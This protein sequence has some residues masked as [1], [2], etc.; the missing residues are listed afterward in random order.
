MGKSEKCCVRKS[1]T[2]PTD[3][4]SLRTTTL[5]NLLKSVDTRLNYALKDGKR[6]F[7]LSL[8]HTAQRIMQ[9][10]L[11][12]DEIERRVA[13]YESSRLVSNMIT[14]VLQE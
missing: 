8:A 11:V 9:Y 7:P 5:L 13:I 10:Y 3:L 2:F 6:A 14:C 12:V 4:K 1:F